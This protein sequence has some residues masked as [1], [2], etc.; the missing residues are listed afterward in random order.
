M[1]SYSQ[2]TLNDDNQEIPPSFYY[3]VDTRIQSF[4]VKLPK[5]P[6]KG[7]EIFFFDGYHT[8]SKNNLILDCNDN[9]IMEISENLICDTDSMKICLIFSGYLEGWKGLPL[10]YQEQLQQM[11]LPVLQTTENHP[12]QTNRSPK[13]WINL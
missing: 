5:Y 9:K 10:E 3:I 12:K 4:S 13:R 2:L 7:D 6:S 8:F 11:E 1:R